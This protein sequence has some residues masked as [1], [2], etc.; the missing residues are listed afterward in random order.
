MLGIRLC[1]S[2]VVAKNP[3]TLELGS[4]SILSEKLRLYLITFWLVSSTQPKELLVVVDERSINKL[5]I[6]TSKNVIDC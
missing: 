5:G 6:L 1:E 2:P 3:I 4:I